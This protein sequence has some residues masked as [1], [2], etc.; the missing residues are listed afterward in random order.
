[1]SH[2]IEYYMLCVP[3]HP[4]YSNKIIKLSNSLFIFLSIDWYFYQ[5][6]NLS[7]SAFHNSSL[8]NCKIYRINKLNKHFK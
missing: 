6:L 2:F 3:L 4:V 7:T 5:S 1:M 8:Q